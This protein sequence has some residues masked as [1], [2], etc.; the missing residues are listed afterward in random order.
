MIY[1]CDNRSGI[2][3]FKDGQAHLVRVDNFIL[4]FAVPNFTADHVV[5]VTEKE[6]QCLME[7]FIYR[8]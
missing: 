5:V 8:D 6:Y 2:K 1:T 7:L 3:I 4:D